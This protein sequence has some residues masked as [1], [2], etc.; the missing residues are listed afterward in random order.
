MDGPLT[1]DAF[2]ELMLA[3]YAGDDPM[4][5]IE[6]DDGWVDAAPA[7]RY[8]D[9]PETTPDLARALDL[10]RGR[11]LDVGAGGGRCAVPLLTRGHAVT[12]LD[13]SPGAIEVCRRRGVTDTYLGTVEEHAAD[14]ARY[15]T[16]L[17]YGNNLGLLTGPDRAVRFLAALGR[18]AAPDARIVGQGLDPHPGAGRHAAYH[19]RNRTRGRMTG[20]VDL[21]VRYRGIASPWFG[22][23]FASADELR[24]LVDGTGWRVADVRPG[25]ASPSYLA[26]LTRHR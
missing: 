11:V 24:G 17:L 21:R 26:V 25:V 13:T 5:I 6:R 10:V 18:L 2:G 1:G 9:G 8:F 19:E 7:R 3:A 20:Q 4:E 16:F 22:Y 12:A 14:R 23:L 15:D